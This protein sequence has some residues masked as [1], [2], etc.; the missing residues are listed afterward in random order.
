MMDGLHGEMRII[1]SF[2]LMKYYIM[3]L[4]ICYISKIANYTRIISHGNNLQKDIIMGLIF[5]DII[6]KAYPIIFKF[7]YLKKQS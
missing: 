7:I 1:A 6:E 3:R 4:S 2:L 5:S